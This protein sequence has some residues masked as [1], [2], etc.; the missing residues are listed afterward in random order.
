MLLP[1]EVA[2]ELVAEVAAEVADHV[3]KRLQGD[4]LMWLHQEGHSRMWLHHFWGVEPWTCLRVSVQT[5]SG[6]ASV[7]ELLLEE[8]DKV[9]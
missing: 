7:E 4:G 5:A 9:A 1:L 8:L 6:G 2:A 3:M